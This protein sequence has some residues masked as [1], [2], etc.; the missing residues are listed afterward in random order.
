M[1]V[2]WHCGFNIMNYGQHETGQHG[3]CGLIVH[4]VSDFRMTGA[5]SS[6][7]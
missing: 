7:A 1:G 4:G 6:E 2:F 3:V 5:W